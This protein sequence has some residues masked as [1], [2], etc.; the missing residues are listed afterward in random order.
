MTG[1]SS[2]TCPQANSRLSYTVGHG[3]QAGCRGL[4]TMNPLHALW[5]TVAPSWSRYAD[6]IDRRGAAV[7]EAMLAAIDVRPGDHV[8][9]LGCGPG[10]LGIA[11]AERVGPTGRVVLSD[12][13]PEMVAVAAQ[14]VERLGLTN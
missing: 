11:A 7:T 4:P 8:I 6:T 14:R 12:V 5:S 9:E 13:V 2:S 10:G 3:H 1:R